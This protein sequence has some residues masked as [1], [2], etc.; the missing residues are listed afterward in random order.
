[1]HLS[2]EQ[3][4]LNRKFSADDTLQETISFD[5][6]RVIFLKKH[7]NKYLEKIKM[8][9]TLTCAAS[10]KWIPVL[11]TFILIKIRRKDYYCRKP[12]TVT[13][14]ITQ[15]IYFICWHK[16]WLLF[17][18]IRLPHNPKFDDPDEAMLLKRLLETEKI[19]VTSIFAFF[20]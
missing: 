14:R 2:L 12:L 8:V 9:E 20:P 5:T 7:V 18:S 17:F 1:M 11:K 6:R 4:L 10:G 15:L 19:L 16:L 3:S 13:V